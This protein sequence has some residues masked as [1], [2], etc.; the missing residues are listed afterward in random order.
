MMTTCVRVDGI[1]WY[2][3]D[4]DEEGTVAAYTVGR[5]PIIEIRVPSQSFPVDAEYVDV[6]KAVEKATEKVGSCS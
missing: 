1:D 3:R 6:A 4:A 5:E 2:E